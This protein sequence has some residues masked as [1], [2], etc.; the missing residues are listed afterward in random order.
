[1]LVYI[2]NTPAIYIFYLHKNAKTN[3][4]TYRCFQI[5]PLYH[6]P[7]VWATCYIHG[8][9]NG[10]LGHFIL[11]HTTHKGL[12][13]TISVHCVHTCPRTVQLW[14]FHTLY[15]TLDTSPP[16]KWNILFLSHRQNGRML[17][18]D[19]NVQ[20]FCLGITCRHAILELIAHKQQF[21]LEYASMPWH[22]FIVHLE[23]MY[24]T[25]EDRYTTATL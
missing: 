12:L 17:H 21:E 18:T 24:G 4:N 7:T 14:A 22:K 10:L 9:V 2:H 6:Q 8:E 25:Q 11:A 20:C 15:I 19:K 23:Y 1:M 16:I 13:P 3:S 5:E